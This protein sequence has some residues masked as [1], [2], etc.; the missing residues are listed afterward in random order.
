MGHGTGMRQ[1]L[2]GNEEMKKSKNAIELAS[3]DILFRRVLQTLAVT[4]AFLL[5]LCGGITGSILTLYLLLYT[6][7]W[8]VTLFYLYWIWMLDRDICDTGGRPINWVRDWTLWKLVK[9]YF[10]TRLERVPWIE[11][12]PKKNYLLCC[13][14]H[15]IFPMGP[16]AS[17]AASANGF[18]KLFPNHVPHPLTLKFNFFLPLLR[19]LALSLGMCS[20]SAKSMN[21]LLN[22]PAGG[23]AA[24]LMVGGAEEAYYCRPGNY[25]IVLKKRKG[26]VKIAL[27]NGSPLVPVFTFGEINVFNQLANPKGSVVRSVQDWFKRVIGVVPVIPFGRGHS[28]IPF[29]TPLVTIIGKPIEVEKTVNPTQEQ[30]ETLHARFTKELMELFEE[31]KY[32][33]LSDPKNVQLIIE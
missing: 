17:F 30:I 25:T 24:I 15:G 29:R 21:S 13:F 8:P 18:C 3:I 10:P 27:Q 28:F 31:Q 1:E 11:F 5:M 9:E 19:D 26:F 20:V 33:Y 32:N 2:D 16:F 4:V 7:Y 22:D 14:P 6:N 23:K 12:D